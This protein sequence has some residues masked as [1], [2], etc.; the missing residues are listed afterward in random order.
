MSVERCTPGASRFSKRNV[1]SLP[2]VTLNSHKN[3]LTQ[4][5]IQCTG[6]QIPGTNFCTVAPQYGTCFLSA[7][8]RLEL[9][10]TSLISG[11][12]VAQWLTCCATNRKV[13][14]SIPDGVIGIFH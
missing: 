1:A 3:D 7:F 8:W 11:T 4:R 13:A 9:R 6:A 5:C 2:T 14:G 10:G 12:A